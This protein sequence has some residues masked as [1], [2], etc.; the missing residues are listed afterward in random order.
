MK[1]AGHAP[2]WAEIEPLLDEALALAPAERERFLQ[3]L[4]PARRHCR[5]TLARLL[6]A[7]AAA[8]FGDQRPGADDFAG[9]VLCL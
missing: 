5:D 8:E 2:G 1:E 7:D 6:A 3:T 9:G 4:P